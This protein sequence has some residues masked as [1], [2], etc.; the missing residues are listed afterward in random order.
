MDNNYIQ[1]KN[2]EYEVILPNFCENPESSRVRIFAY[3][4]N[5]E[6]ND[7]IIPLKNGKIIDDSSFLSR[8][9]KEAQV[10][11]FLLVDRFN[12]GNTSNDQ[13]VKDAEVHPK[14]NYMGGDIKGIIKK[15]DDGFF[16]KLG[17]NT[18]W[19]S[20]VH[21]NPLTAYVEFPEPH[22]KFSGYHG[23]WP[24]HITK[25]DHR[26]GTNAEMKEL[27][28]KAHANNM[29]ILVDFVANHLHEE[30][31]IIK[32]NPH[33]ATQLN[34]PDG[35]KNIRLW[36]EYRLTTWFDTFLPTLDLEK[37]EVYDCISDSA[38]FF[39]KTF[40]I[41][42]FR[43]DA[44]KHIPEI[45]WRELT[46]KIKKF[47]GKKNN[48]SVYQIGETYGSRELI[49]SYVGSG[50]MDGQFDFNLFFD[51]KNTFIKD[52]NSFVNLK[53]SLIESL[54]YYGHNH[55]MGNI[56]GNHDQAR[57]ISYAGE[58]LRFDEDEKEAGWKR[59]VKVENPVGYKKLSALTAFILTI[60]GV[61]VIYYGD[62]FGMPGAG[63]PD[64]RRMM[65]F[66]NLS[67]E[68]KT[69]REKTEKLVKLRRSSMPLIFG[70]FKFIEVTETEMIYT[71]S[72]FGQTVLVVFNKNAQKKLFKINITEIDKSEMLKP[73][74]NSNY[75]INKSVLELEISG[76]SFDVFIL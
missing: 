65:K 53:N 10:L 44:T 60:P 43:H 27:V 56:T 8:S 18:I 61:P 62:E 42:G 1:K 6:S 69:L 7:L 12:N 28:E 55:L 49:G 35:R 74:F 39:L 21:Q 32:K 38:I 34:L 24:V 9:D 57:V 37:K 48:K 73:I 23:Y 36:D 30:S 58:G 46:K 50:K 54:S 25:I 2:S 72:Y 47:S 66:D 67:K 63:D 64:N 45:F 15:I 68:E 41:D 22:R 11:Y 31:P 26:F 71:R 33:W 70:D 29:N 20:P 5:G 13:P 17:V 59:D 75:K 76:Y 14:A 3:N 52:D 16:Q 4:K 51:A 40:D 19:L